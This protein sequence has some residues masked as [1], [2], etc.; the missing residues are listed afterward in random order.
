ML[1]WNLM[2]DTKQETLDKVTNKNTNKEAVGCNSDS[3][4]RKNDELEPK[5]RTGAMSNKLCSIISNELLLELDAKKV[6]TLVLAYEGALPGIHIVALWLK[7]FAVQEGIIDKALSSSLKPNKKDAL[8]KRFIASCHLKA[9]HTMRLLNDYVFLKSLYCES[10]IFADE[11]YLNGPSAKARVDLAQGVVNNE[12]LRS[13]ALNILAYL[14]D[15]ESGTN[16]SFINTINTSIDTKTSALNT[17]KREDSLHTS[18]FITEKNIYFKFDPKIA[19]VEDNKEPKLYLPPLVT[20]E[21]INAVVSLN[22]KYFTKITPALHCLT[23]L[24]DKAFNRVLLVCQD[25]ALRN[26]PWYRLDWLANNGV[27]ALEKI[28]KFLMCLIKN[29]LGQEVGVEIYDQAFNANLEVNSAYLS[30]QKLVKTNWQKVQLDARIYLVLRYFMHVLAIQDFQKG[31]KSFNA[32][33]KLLPGTENKSEEKPMERIELNESLVYNPTS[34]LVRT[35]YINHIADKTVLTAIR[36][37]SNSGLELN[38]A[39]MICAKFYEMQENRTLQKVANISKN[40]CNLRRKLKII[41]KD[42]E[43]FNPSFR[44]YAK[45]QYHYLR[46]T[47][48]VVVANMLAPFLL[49]NLKSNG[50]L[51]EVSAT[52]ADLLS[53]YLSN[54]CCYG[55]ALDYIGRLKLSSSLTFLNQSKE[56]LSGHYFAFEPQGFDLNGVNITLQQLRGEDNATLSVKDFGTKNMCIKAK[57]AIKDCLQNSLIEHFKL[58]GFRSYQIEQVFEE[59]IFSK[60]LRVLCEDFA[61]HNLSYLLK[62]DLSHGF[63][64]PTKYIHACEHLVIFNAPHKKKRVKSA[65]VIAMF[66]REVQEILNGIQN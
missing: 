60:I 59:R 24:N 35:D 15:A 32:N 11:G 52:N 9:P 4:F 58:F 13:K 30:S 41:F 2:T 36:S 10:Q 27:Q 22:L 18:K 31:I 66:K 21:H 48:P 39:S 33:D 12:S 53:S 65:A 40:S 25:L 28:V 50:Y 37:L 64:I 19:A 38:V 54:D 5:T 57:E 62:A 43:D 20:H 17:I 42:E 6:A 47:L 49:S 46:V 16:A 23:G 56:E 45:A 3:I 34:V 8:D 26:I 63:L 1:K 51:I 44:T 61:Q 7:A 14:L 29:F 55:S